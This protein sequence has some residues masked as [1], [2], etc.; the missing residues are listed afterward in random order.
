MKYLSIF[1]SQQKIDT[2]NF[3]NNDFEKIIQNFVPNKPHG[4]D[5]ISIRMIKIC[6]KSICKLLKL[7][8]NQCIDT[9]SF[10]LERK[11]ANRVSIHKEGDKQCLKNY[12]PVSLLPIYGKIL[13]RPIFNEIFDFLIKN[14]LISSNQSGVKRGDSCIKLL[15]SITHEVYK[16][17][18]K[19]FEVRGA[20]LDISKS[21]DKVWHDGIIFKLKQ[22]GI[23]GKVLSVLSDFS[24]DRK[25]RLTLNGQ[26]F[27]WK[28]VNEGVPNKPILGLLLFL[29]YINDLADGLSSNA[30]LFADDTSLF[31]IID[32]VDTSANELNNDLYQINKWSFQWKISFN[33]DP[34]KQPQ[35][36]IFS[37]KTKRIYHSSL[38]FTVSQSPYHKTRRHIS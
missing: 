10:P 31:S 13:E 16:S 1:I 24:K 38:R 20:F 18:D 33:P 29:L 12:R 5:K 7:I 34:S 28:G 14:N 37:R 30:K 23:S 11:K 26:V 21:F 25:Q 36:I 15:L 2:L 3:S 17:F 8:F 19:W 22:N 32:N 4:H 35:E 27:S 9:G 6:G